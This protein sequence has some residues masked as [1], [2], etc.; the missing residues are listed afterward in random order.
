MGIN[1]KFYRILCCTPPELE[2]ERLVFEAEVARLVEQVT[3]PDE[4]LFA[5]ASLR[6]PIIAANQKLAI[7][8]NIRTCEFFIQIFGEQWPEPVFRDFVEYSIES[9]ADPSRVT[10]AACVFFRNF[11]AAAPELRQLRFRL[12]SGGE[13]ELRDFAN[14]EDLSRQLSEVL[15]AWYA[16]LKPERV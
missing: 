14:A 9:L 5:A 1:F 4:V 8:S 2:P 3:M 6:P 11:D 15:A 10:R 13:C 12:A 7:E 16:P